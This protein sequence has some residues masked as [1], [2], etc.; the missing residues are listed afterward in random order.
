MRCSS[1]RLKWPPARSELPVEMFLEG[2]A[3]PKPLPGFPRLPVGDLPGVSFSPLKKWLVIPQN[4]GAI[5]QNFLEGHEDSRHQYHNC[6]WWR[7]PELA[8]PKS[9]SQ[10]NHS[11][12]QRK[13]QPTMVSTMVSSLCRMSS[14]HSR[15][16][17]GCGRR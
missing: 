3:R 5:T 13:Y 9:E 14:V 15:R 7:N 8:P 10:G 4:N 6:G 11:I 17:F 1:R 12:P 2:A 16:P